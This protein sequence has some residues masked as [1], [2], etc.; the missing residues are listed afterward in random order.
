LRGSGDLPPERPGSYWFSPPSAIAIVGFLASLTFGVLAPGRLGFFLFLGFSALWTARAVMR[1]REGYGA[2]VMT[3]TAVLLAL[4]TLVAWGMSFFSALTDPLLP[5]PSP[6]L[7][8][9]ADPQAGDRIAWYQAERGWCFDLD[10]MT[11]AGELSFVTIAS[12]DE[13]HDA[14]ALTTRRD[15]EVLTRVGRA[16]ADAAAGSVDPSSSAP[17]DESMQ[18]RSDDPL[19]APMT[20]W[21]EELSSD[22]LAAGAPESLTVVPIYASTVASGPHPVLVC[23]LVAGDGGVLTRDFTR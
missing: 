10:G 1:W 16:L 18:P 23:V 21:C 13:P 8:E 2:T 4:V 6:T 5:T 20:Q 12:C 15:G 17:L 22:V 19:R 7:P 14:Q 11:R 9:D 3:A